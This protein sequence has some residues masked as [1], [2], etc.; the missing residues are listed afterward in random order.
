[1]KKSYWFAVAHVALLIICGL[2]LEFAVK[3]DGSAI[4]KLL[5]GFFIGTYAVFGK[6]IAKLILACAI[7]RKIPVLD[8][9]AW[10]NSFTLCALALLAI[11]GLLAWAVSWEGSTGVYFGFAVFIAALLSDEGFVPLFAEFVPS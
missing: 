9:S 11:A 5:A 1:M 7:K 3:A 2:L 4:Q 10:S 8:K 6:E